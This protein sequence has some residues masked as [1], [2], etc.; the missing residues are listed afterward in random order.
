VAFIYLLLTLSLS[1]LLHYLGR[2]YSNQW[3]K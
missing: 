1:K 2:K 3:L